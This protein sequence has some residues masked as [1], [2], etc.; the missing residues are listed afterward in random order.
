[1]EAKMAKGDE[2][3]TVVDWSKKPEPWCWIGPQ[4]RAECEAIVEG[5]PMPVAPKRETEGDRLR[6]RRHALGF[7]QDQLGHLAGLHPKTVYVVESNRAGSDALCHVR[8][9]LDRAEAERQAREAA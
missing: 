9:A 3:Q 4:F 2:T 5:R 6:Q 7:T 1:M 8:S